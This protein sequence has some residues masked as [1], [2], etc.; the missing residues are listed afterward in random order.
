M[1]M[2]YACQRALQQRLTVAMLM[3][4][5]VS[6][7]ALP[8]GGAQRLSEQNSVL[9]LRESILAAY[10]LSLR[11]LRDH[12]A[13]AAVSGADS[14]ASAFSHDDSAEELQLLNQLQD[15]AID[16]SFLQGSNTASGD[17][18]TTSSGISMDPASS[19]I[20]EQQPV[21]A[22]H[23]PLYL[24]RQVC[25]LPP[26]PG[27]AAMTAEQVAAQYSNTVQQ[28]ALQLSL[29][30]AEQKPPASRACGSTA[31]KSPLERIKDCLMK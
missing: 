12:A 28:L 25:R 23:N 19:S 17:G 1:M 11:W 10:S 2:C 5:C 6:T 15:L 14:L 13:A 24:M 26:F 16:S 3:K 30:R 20:S 9:R 31:D 18:S 8:T 22:E 7:S 29:H 4:A 27:A 21:A